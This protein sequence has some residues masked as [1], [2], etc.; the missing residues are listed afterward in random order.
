[1]RLS[2]KVHGLHAMLLADIDCPPS[3]PPPH[4]GAIPESVYIHTEDVSDVA[5]VSGRVR[6]KVKAIGAL[7]DA[8]RPQPDVPDPPKPLP[9]APLAQVRCT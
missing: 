3:P 1:M 6:V 4:L 2:G 8:P 7:S 9:T 5:Y